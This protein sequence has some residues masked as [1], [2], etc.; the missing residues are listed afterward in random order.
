MTFAENATM[1]TSFLSL[2]LGTL[3]WMTFEYLDYRVI[4]WP[5]VKGVVFDPHY[6]VMMAMAYFVGF[7]HAFPVGWEFWYIDQL[8]GGP[9]LMAVDGFTRRL[10][11]VLCFYVSGKFIEKFGELETVALSLF[12]YALGFLALSFIRIAWL[13]LV[14]DIFYA[15]GFAFSLS[16]LVVHFS[17]AAT[18]A[19]SATIQG[20]LGISWRSAGDQLGISWGLAGDQRAS[21]VFYT[22]INLANLWFRW[23]GKKLGRRLTIYS[24]ES[25]PPR[26]ITSI[27]RIIRISISVRL[28]SITFL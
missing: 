10:F 3:P 6:I 18:K 14:V 4:N 27:K 12:L 7:C 26:Y 2:A 21:G 23:H 8:S 1:D 5:E 24:G 20:E 25:V 9:V 17:K 13:V 22:A 11:V 16:S 28:Y 15:A 19:S